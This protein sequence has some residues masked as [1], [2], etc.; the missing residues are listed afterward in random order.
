MYVQKSIEISTQIPR[1]IYKI[2][3]K[4]YDFWEIFWKMGL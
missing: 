3:M 4:S 1:Y 2:I